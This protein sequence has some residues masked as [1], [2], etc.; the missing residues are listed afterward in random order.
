ML[1]SPSKGLDHSPY[2]KMLVERQKCKQNN[3]T[4]KI[5]LFVDKNEPPF[6]NTMSR[7]MDAFDTRMGTF[8]QQEINKDA[9]YDKFVQ[10]KLA[11]I[12]T[13]KGYAE[14]DPENI[15]DKERAPKIS[16]PGPA[17]AT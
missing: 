15:V 11:L 6:I 9:V 16:A 3:G 14:A 8:G 1:K 17:F 7:T 2:A 10:E 5:N 4:D 13:T 12:R